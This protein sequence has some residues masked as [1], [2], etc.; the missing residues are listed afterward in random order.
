MPDLRKEVSKLWWSI[1]DACFTG[2]GIKKSNGMFMSTANDFPVGSIYD[3]G[4]NFWG[5]LNKQ[6]LF[7]DQRKLAEDF[8]DYPTVAPEGNPERPPASFEIGQNN[9]AGLELFGNVVDQTTI[10]QIS[11]EI[12]AN[13]QKSTLK[14]V[15]IDAWGIDII[16]AGEVKIFF[17][18]HIDS[19]NVRIKEI[20]K[21]G[22]FIAI[23]GIWIKGISFESGLDKKVM[24]EL[25]AIYEAKKP[26]FLDAGIQYRD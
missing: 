25:Q 12:A 21:G 3:I 18:K 4:K 22:K 19:D 16:P 2:A 17:Q 20:L 24:A 26:D 13:I 9:A 11:A 5:T 1:N 15:K 14:T 6:N 10:G 7:F 8:P 23:Q